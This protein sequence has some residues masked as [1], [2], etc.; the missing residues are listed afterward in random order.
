MQEQHLDQMNQ[1]YLTVHGHFYQPPREDPVSG[2]IPRE[3]GAAP[4]HDFNE[5]ILTECYRPNAK[6]GNFAGMSFD[7]GPTLGLWM[8]RRHPLVM[9]E[10][11]ASDRDA[12]ART[13]YGNALMQSFHHTILPLANERDRRTELRWGRRWFEYTFGRSPAGIWLPETAVD[14]ATLQACVEE[15]LWFTL[16]SP[17]QAADAIDPRQ[18]YQ[19]QLPGGFQFSVVFYDGGLSG[20]VSFQPDVTDSAPSF[21]AN[22]LVPRLADWQV[23]GDRNSLGNPLILIATDGEVYGHHHRFKDLFLQDLIESRAA[24]AGITP[25]GLEHFLRMNPAAG[26]VSLIERSSWGCPHDLL[27]WRGDCDCTA[28]DGSWKGELRMAFDDLAGRIDELTDDRLS[29]AM[30]VDPWALRDSWVDVV[31]GA[32]SE[33]QWL[34]RRRLPTSGPDKERLIRLMRAQQSRLAMYA[35][36]AFYWD[37]LTRIEAGYGVRSALHAAHLADRVAGN[38]ELVSSFTAKLGKITGWKSEKSAAELYAAD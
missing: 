14:L 34:S 35:S 6:L 9:A 15:G 20:A 13:G 4:F 24:E 36:C 27:R 37:D 25:V 31:I 16:L 12:V 11:V 30:G 3:P 19:V 22:E 8:Q 10:I 32:A 29:L 21:V 5:K 1:R 17:D 18:P 33:D 26:E 7:I 23:D 28:G 38:D 2:L